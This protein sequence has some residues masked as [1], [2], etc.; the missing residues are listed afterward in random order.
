MPAKTDRLHRPKYR[1]IAMRCVSQVAAEVHG[2][3]ADNFVA[4]NGGDELL[5]LVL[6]SF[7]EAGM[8]SH[9]DQRECTLE[10]MRCGVCAHTHV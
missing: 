6:T 4:V 1:A 3:S 8:P 5:R 2:L 9:P 7:V 10:S